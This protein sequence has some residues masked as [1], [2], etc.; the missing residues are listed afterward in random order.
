MDEVMARDHLVS[1]I[2]EASIISLSPFTYEM[3]LYGPIKL[4]NIAPVMQR[5]K[6][7]KLQ[8]IKP[9]TSISVMLSFMMAPRSPH[10]F[11]ARSL[12]PSKARR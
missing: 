9:G 6:T 2:N 8:R 4:F 10:K 12:V 1:V 5:K 11:K 3:Q 7:I